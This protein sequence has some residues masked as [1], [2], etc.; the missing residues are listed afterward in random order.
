LRAA[1]ERIAQLMWQVDSLARDTVQLRRRI[2]SLQ[3]ARRADNADLAKWRS[4]WWEVRQQLAEATPPAAPSDTGALV[5]PDTARPPVPLP[6]LLAVA[7]STIGACTQALQT[8]DAQV[9]AERARGD[10]AE[11]RAQLLT[12]VVDSLQ[13]PP[14]KPLWY[15]ATKKVGESYAIWRAVR[16]VWDLTRRRR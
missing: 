6:V 9:A 1:A 14:K 3:V 2:D 7:D 4:R 5:S 10:N 8:C 13:H 11:T 15:R 16:V 12:S